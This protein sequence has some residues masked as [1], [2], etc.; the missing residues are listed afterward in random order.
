[1]WF[2]DLTGVHGAAAACSAVASALGL[3]LGADEPAL[4]EHLARA[5]ARRGRILV[6]LDNFEQLADVAEATLGRWLRAAPR[7]RFLVTSR[8]ALGLAG[9]HLWPLH[10]LQLPPPGLRDEA[11]LAA[12]ESIDLFVRRARQLRPDLVLRPDDLAAIA[13][14][15]R[16]L[17]GILWRSSWPRRASRCSRSSSCA[18][19]WSNDWPCWCATARADGTRRCGGRSPIRGTSSAPPSRTASRGARSSPAASPS[20]PRRQ[21]SPTRW[22][23]SSRCSSRCACASGARDASPRPRRRA[24]LLAV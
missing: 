21:C 15:V 10:P 24:A 9:E 2:C 13:E 7:A 8:V 17:D 11:G 23:R 22:A 3:Q 19:A 16:R 4:A 6:V 18:T 1:M 20:R 5:L 12:I 14:V